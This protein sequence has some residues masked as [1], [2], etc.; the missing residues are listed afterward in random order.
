MATRIHHISQKWNVIDNRKE[1]LAQQY[2]ITTKTLPIHIT[3]I[4]LYMVHAHTQNTGCSLSL[5]FVFTSYFH[6][7]FFFFLMI[8]FG[9]LN[10]IYVLNWNIDWCFRRNVSLKQSFSIYHN[11][12]T[13]NSQSSFIYTLHAYEWV[14]FF[15]SPL[16]NLFLEKL[17]SGNKIWPLTPRTKN[18]L[19]TRKIRFPYVQ[20]FFWP[21]VKIDLP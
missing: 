1:S 2:E 13:K 6:G 3:L 16:G 7:K 19:H 9:S 14:S 12:S 20:T 8:L 15:L 11:S 17:N 5:I 18:A 21:L 4:I 10:K